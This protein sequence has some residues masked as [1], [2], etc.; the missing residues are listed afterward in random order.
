MTEENQVGGGIHLFGPINNTDIYNNTVYVQS[1]S[2]TFP[3]AV[4]IYNP[5]NNVRFY[6]NIFQTRDNARL[7]DISSTAAT[8]S[9]G[10]VFQG[11][12]YFS[13][14]TPFRLQWGGTNYNSLDSWRTA[15]AQER[16]NGQVTGSS[17]DPL[18]SSPGTGPNINNTDI[19]NNLSAYRLDTNSPMIDRGLDLGQF[20]INPGNQDFFGSH[21][22]QGLGYDIGAHEF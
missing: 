22:P 16:L 11:N 13:S 2:T 15:T 17:V 1:S 14:G 4:L 20:G 19:L 18:L 10:L 5:V 7:I 6:N 9:T 8:Q 12:N 3:D 21:L